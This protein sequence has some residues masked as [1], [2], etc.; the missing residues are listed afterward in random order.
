MGKKKDVIEKW[1]TKGKRG[2]RWF[3]HR[4]APNGEI[5]FC[6]QGYLSRGGR[7]SAVRRIS[8]KEGVIVKAR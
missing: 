3:F 5:L 7:N 1:M 2:Y 8:S 4:K 6:S